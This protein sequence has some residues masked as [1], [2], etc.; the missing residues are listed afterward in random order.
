MRVRINEDEDSYRKR[1]KI[2]KGSM[3]HI[4][5]KE[6]MRKKIRAAVQSFLMCAK[7]RE[8]PVIPEEIGNEIVRMGNILAV[9]RTQI[10]KDRQGVMEYSPHPEYP[11]RCVDQLAKVAVGLAMIENEKEVK[12]NHM[13]YLWRIALDCVDET[14]LSVFQS[15]FEANIDADGKIT[16]AINEKPLRTSDIGERCNMPSRTAKDRLEDLCYLRL[17]RREGKEKSGYTWILNN[18]NPIIEDYH[19]MHNRRRVYVYFKD[20]EKT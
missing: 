6:E 10:I 15:L 1:L 11:T 9:L 17:V 5:E 16:Y 2:G 7:D 14:R 20:R 13:P 19:D 4:H 8:R 18:L 12:E 3:T